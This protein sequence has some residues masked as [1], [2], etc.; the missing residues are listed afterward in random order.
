MN[1][2]TFVY[3]VVQQIASYRVDTG[4]RLPMPGLVFLTRVWLMRSTRREVTIRYEFGLG[5]WFVVFDDDDEP[6]A[7]PDQ[8]VFR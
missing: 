8:G 5:D 1:P 3:S 4:V 2:V 7:R 6:P